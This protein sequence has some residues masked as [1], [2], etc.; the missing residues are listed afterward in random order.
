MSERFKDKTWIYNSRLIT[1][2]EGNIKNSPVL[3]TWEGQK[4]RNALRRDI[5]AERSKKEEDNKT[6]KIKFEHWFPTKAQVEVL[7]EIFWN[8]YRNNDGKGDSIYSVVSYGAFRYW[9]KNYL[10][11]R[12]RMDGY[13]LQLHKDGSINPEDLKLVIEDAQTLSKSDIMNLFKWIPIDNKSPRNWRG[14]VELWR[15]I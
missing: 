11:L 3:N 1:E 15:I 12:V 2:Q 4:A 7:T 5:E 14:K 6:P 10:V 9:D 8:R 13:V